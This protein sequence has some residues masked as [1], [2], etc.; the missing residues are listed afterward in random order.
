MSRTKVIHPKA[1]KNHL[2]KLLGWKLAF[3][4]R[5][6]VNK[7]PAV[8]FNVIK[9]L[10]RDRTSALDQDIDAVITGIWGCANTFVSAAF[11]QWN[12]EVVTTHHHHIP[13]FAIRAAKLE[14]PC[15]VLIRH[16]VDALASTTTRDRVEFSNRGFSWALKDYADYY[17]SI[18]DY[19]D[20]FETADFREVITDFPAVIKRVND[21]FGSSFI[22]PDPDSEEYKELSERIRWRGGQRYHTIEDVKQALHEPD[23]EPDRLRAEK[24]YEAFCLR[25]NIPMRKDS[26]DRT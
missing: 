21:K 24:A 26:K 6:F 19:S 12:P 2:R 25:N 22:A 18:I 10:K 7:R 1:N 20:H 14:L 17:E 15:L 4:A 11:K 23:L 9:L 13:A 5:A 3:A 8:Y 16:P